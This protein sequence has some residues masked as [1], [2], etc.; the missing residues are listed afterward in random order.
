MFLRS[1][2]A[3]LLVTMSLQVIADS[4]D[5]NMNN[6]MA[7]IK[8]G[9]SASGMAEGNAELQSGMLY[10]DKGNILLEAGLKVK[11]NKAQSSGGGEPQGDGESEEEDGGDSSVS[12]V[13]IES[14]MFGGGGVKGL[15][16][17]INQGAATHTVACFGFGAEMGFA[18][19]TAVPIQL[20][21]ELFTTLRLITFLDAE[22]YS[23]YSVRI[24][25]IVSPQAKVYIGYHNIGF[26]IRKSVGSVT[27]DNGSY[28]GISASF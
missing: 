28:I 26:G 5:V 14:G 19:P 16:G 10:N 4:M 23:E 17:S 7:Q 25:A 27:L 22:R 11:G 20:V 2:V 3:I 8:F 1:L 12:S 24:E 9:S 13:P 6:N 15:F 18:L 21:G